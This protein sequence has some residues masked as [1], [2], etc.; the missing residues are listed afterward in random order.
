[1]SLCSIASRWR[2]ARAGLEK[3]AGQ[4]CVRQRAILGPACLSWAASALLA[5]PSLSWAALSENVGVSIRAMSLGNA[6]TADPGGIEAVHYNPAALTKLKGKHHDLTILLARIRNSAE[7]EAPENWEGIF[8]FKEDPVLGT[9]STSDQHAIY[10]PGRGLSRP[11]L[12][13]IPAP[14]S[15]YSYNDPESRFTY[16]FMPYASQFITFDR[17]RRGDD[18]PA[19]FGGRTV[20]LQRFNYFVPSMGYKVN[21]AW[22]FGLTTSLAHHAVAIDTDFR[23]PNQLIALVGQL[24]KALCPEGGNPIDTV[25]FGLCNKGRMDPFRKIANLNFQVTVPADPTIT[26]GTLWE[27]TDWFSLGMVYSTESRMRMT[28]TYKITY[29][30]N[31]REFIRGVS[32]SALGPII[33]TS[34]AQP[35]SIP[36]KEE[37]NVTLSLTNPAHFQ[38][39]TKFKLGRIQL[40]A[41]ASWT[42]WGKWDKLTFDFD[43][44]LAALQMARL[45]GYPD[46]SKLEMPFKAKSVWSGGLGLQVDVT[47]RLQLRL[48]GEYRRS[49]IGPEAFD[50]IGPLTDAMLWG[51][52]VGFMVDKDTVID[53][54]MSMMKTRHTAEPNT[55]CKLNCTNLLNVVYNPYAG[56]R[57]TAGLKIDAAGVTVRKRF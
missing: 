23:A 27:P 31:I 19:R 51:I 24:Q 25:L 33:L 42:D 37:G 36:E 43:T 38:I 44:E 39:G 22:S 4:D 11:N 29:D 10:I 21:D 28:G 12:P 50:T 8:G 45:F 40:N 48:G 14:L 1:M 17:S 2:H 57:V 9:R 26:I 18:E 13:L 55:S 16:A 49:S 7:F 5:M 32:N 15:G 30:P 53:A 46:A 6:V 35:T 54:T 41:D 56:E 34:L 52:G 3:M 20:V 47:R